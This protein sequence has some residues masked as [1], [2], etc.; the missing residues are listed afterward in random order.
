MGE[1]LG[2][3][4]RN[5]FRCL[6]VVDFPLLEWGEESNRWHAMHHPSPRPSR[7]T[8]GCCKPILERSKNAYDMVINGVEVGGGSIRI[9][10]KQ[11]QSRM[12]EVL[13][14][15]K[16]EAQHQFSSC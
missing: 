14:F 16:D 13:S 2:L 12:F 15:S 8:S 11:L 5:T 9:F 3:R 10:D 7:K 4:D 1:R 6:W